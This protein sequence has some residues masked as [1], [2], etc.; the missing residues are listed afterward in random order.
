MEWSVI[1]RK[2]TSNYGS[3]IS[4]I[5]A[6][7]KISKLSMN[8]EETVG[9]YL[10]R[11]KTLVKS[12]L[13]DATSWHHD[14]DK[15]DAYHVCNGLIKTGLKSRMLRRV[16]Q[17]KTYKDLF[18]NIEDEWDW[19]YFMEDDF[20]GKEDTP[21]TTTELD[22]IN[23]WNE[24]TT[25]DPI[26]A[27]ILVEVNE[28]YDK[29][30]RYPTHRRYWTPGSRPQNSRT[31]FR[32]GQ[33]YQ[34]TFTPRYNSRHQ[35]TTVA[36]Q[37]YTFNGTTLNANVNYAPG[38][39]NTGA[40]FNTYQVPYNQQQTQTYT[41]NQQYHNNSFADQSSKTLQPDT[42]TIMEQLK[43]LLLSHKNPVHQVNEV[44]AM[45]PQPGTTWDLKTT[46]E[47]PTTQED[48]SK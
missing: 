2:L 27:E 32:G 23:A 41:Q 4:G 3:T 20:T 44:K 6:S 12:K 40:P 13:K 24:T 33:G 1:K 22:K 48:Q 30:S 38:T 25:D 34:K 5:E 7:V 37:A 45:T 26:E 10:T 17:F 19:S 21:T 39:F 16:S 31:P 9:K 18:N 8:S 11:V 42:T 28:V 46:A 43:Q 29:Y 14:I 36:N 35:N 47:L 15:A